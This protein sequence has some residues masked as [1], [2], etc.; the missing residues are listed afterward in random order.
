LKCGINDDSVI[1]PGKT[2]PTVTIAINNA[3]EAITPGKNLFKTGKKLINPAKNRGAKVDLAPQIIPEHFSVNVSRG[4]KLKLA[5]H[6][7]RSDI[8]SQRNKVSPK[9]FR[10]AKF[11]IAPRTVGDETTKA[12][13]YVSN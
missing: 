3:T 8:Y 7:G 2:V 4:A 9:A 5:P 1:A 10:G 6:T 12:M 11:K 13:I